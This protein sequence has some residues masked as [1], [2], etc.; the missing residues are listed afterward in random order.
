MKSY[1]SAIVMVPPLEAWPPIQ[2]IRRIHDHGYVRWLP[3]VNMIYP[4]IPNQLFPEAVPRLRETLA[5]FPSFRVRLRTFS[6]F[7]HSRH[8][9][10]VWL[11]PETE[12]E[13]ALVRLQST[14]E[15]VF[16]HCDDQSHIGEHGFVPHLSVGNDF[17]KA[18][19]MEE[20]MA[21]WQ[22]EWKELSFDVNE[23]YII[24]RVGANNT[25]FDIRYAIPLQPHPLDDAAGLL[26]PPSFPCH[27]IE[28]DELVPVTSSTRVLISNVPFEV[29]E[30]ELT[31]KL[32]VLA[33]RLGISIESVKI[34]R[35]PKLSAR[36]KKS[37]TGRAFVEL[38]TE[39]DQA[40]LLKETLVL[41]DRTLVLSQAQ[42]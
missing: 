12:P 32:E 41:G 11:K 14:L 16:P 30:E 26:P 34:I 1:R 37:S 9:W 25:P 17:R 13:G 38:R 39:A 35:K 31:E 3:H 2:A 18:T 22:R 29:T 28:G 33:Q 21:K 4:F 15:S 6:F 42:A 20:L 5:S 8:S 24:S 7:K 10:T 36:I 27:P 19:D 40:A 23:I